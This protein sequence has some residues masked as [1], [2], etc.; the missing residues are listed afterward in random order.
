MKNIFITGA[1]RGIGLE[2]TKQFLE[3]GDRVFAGARNP[4]QAVSLHQLEDQYKDTLVIVKLEVNNQTEIDSAVS[5]ITNLGHG[6]DI[7]INNAAIKNEREG[8][9]NL[10]MTSMLKVFEVNVLSPVLIIQQF[11]PLLKKGNQARVINIS[12][13]LGS[14]GRN[15]SGIATYS[16]SKTA[17][18]MFTN[19]LANPLKLD[20]IIAIVMDPG[21]VK[22]DMGGSS[23]ELTPTESVSGMINVIDQL[24]LKD[25]GRYYRYN[26]EELPW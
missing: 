2:F 25:S 6:I 15:G 24:D 9:G 16:S 23:A 12:S 18:D 17:L 20:G 19:R 13:S 4:A 8:F 3:R 11:L 21:W 1:N 7:L 22:T 10:K 5:N 14:I 26:R